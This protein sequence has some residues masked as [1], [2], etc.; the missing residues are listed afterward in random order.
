M[1]VANFAEGVGVGLVIGGGLVLYFRS[2][3]SE[4]LATIETRLKNIEGAVTGRKMS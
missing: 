2:K 3:V 4:V 1:N